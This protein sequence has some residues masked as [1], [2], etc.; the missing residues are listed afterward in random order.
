MPI[1]DIATQ[2]LETDN[3]KPSR[4][5]INKSN[6]D[7]EQKFIPSTQIKEII[8]N[9]LRGHRG[10][11]RDFI[12]SDDEKYLISCSEIIDD[13]KP[14][15]LLWRFKKIIEGLEEIEYKLEINGTRFKSEKNLKN[16][17][18]CLDSVNKPI[19]NGQLL[20]IICAGSLNSEIFM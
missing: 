17:L 18:L 9:S 3:T 6:T 19:G 16:W 5:T 14:Y 12:F 4:S 20:W 13:E 10:D 8:V 7:Y 2:S 11:I 15:L 1:K